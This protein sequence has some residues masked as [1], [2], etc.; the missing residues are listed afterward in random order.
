MFFELFKW[1]Y[2]LGWL[3]AWRDVPRSIK[4]AGLEF[5]IPPLLENLFAPWKQLISAPGRS[6]D[7]K[8]RAT[9][10]NLVSRTIG[11]FVRLLTLIAAAVVISVNAI[12]SLVVAVIWPLLPLAAIYFL[13][14]AFTG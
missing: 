1:W 2:G 14:R 11:F 8:F 13:I 9:I 10:D 7:E 12:F 6:I 3:E 5:S 4:R